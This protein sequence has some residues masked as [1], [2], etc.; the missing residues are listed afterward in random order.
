MYK[1][2]KECIYMYMSVRVRYVIAIML[3]L[4]MLLLSS[5]ILGINS[6]KK[7]KLD[8]RLENKKKKGKSRSFSL[9]WLGFMA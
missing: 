3:L 8:G 6:V 2:S 1:V 7:K 5:M 9:F 4:S